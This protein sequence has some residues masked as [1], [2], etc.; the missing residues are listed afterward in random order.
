MYQLV[1]QTRLLQLRIMRHYP[2]LGAWVENG[3]KR[4]YPSNDAHSLANRDNT[5]TSIVVC[6]LMMGV[7]TSS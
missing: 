3:R 7:L 1:T 5:K 4:A 6:A 2:R